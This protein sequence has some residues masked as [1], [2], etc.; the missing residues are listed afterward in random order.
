MTTGCMPVDLAGTVYAEDLSNPWDDQGAIYDKAGW[1]IH[2]LRHMLGDTQFFAAVKAYGQAHA[3]STAVTDDLRTVM[4]SH[5]GH[6]L[7]DFFNQWIYTPYRPVYSIIYEKSGSAGNYTININ[8]SQTQGHMILDLS[9]TALRDFY[10]M[11]VDF[12]VHYTDTTSETFT[13][14]NT[15][16]TQ[17]FVIQTSKE[18]DHVVFDEGINIL[19]VKSE[20]MVTTTTS[21]QPTTTTTVLPTTTTTVQPTLIQLSSFTATRGLGKVI[22][23]WTTESELDN[24]GFN[25]YRAESEEGEYLKINA[26]LIPAKGSLTQ[27]AIYEFVD[28]DVR[29]GKSYWYKLEDIDLNGKSTMHGPVKVSPRLLFGILEG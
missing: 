16:R 10:I 26:A 4:E 29:A 28:R 25:L 22:L 20:T 17:N 7:V 8:L 18:P 14:Q 3:Y 6:S 24:A 2:M 15:Q 9:G 11:P 23:E 13:F 1:V 27:G 21:V 12:T 19:K 5:Y